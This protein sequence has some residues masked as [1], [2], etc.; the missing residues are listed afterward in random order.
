MRGGADNVDNDIGDGI[1][2]GVGGSV[3]PHRK[4]RVV[5]TVACWRSCA[6]LSRPWL[7]GGVAGGAAPIFSC[8]CR[9]RLVVIVLL[10]V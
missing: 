6:E 4:R 7:V 10:L 5:G 2:D 9:Y 8:C 1:G 3:T